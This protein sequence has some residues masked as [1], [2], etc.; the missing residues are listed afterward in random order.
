M[1]IYCIWYKFIKYM[2]L[3]FS[4]KF[5]LKLF[6]QI[7]SF[8]ISFE[9]TKDSKI[10]KKWYSPICRHWS[11]LRS[12]LENII[13]AYFYNKSLSGSYCCVNIQY[14]LINDLNDKINYL[15]SIPL[16]EFKSNM[17]NKTIIKLYVYI[18]SC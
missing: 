4:Y 7:N 14:P 17:L 13:C 8:Y 15:N 2:I 11:L 6:K 3:L 16:L 5:R 9:P 18:E 12:A 10:I 1:F